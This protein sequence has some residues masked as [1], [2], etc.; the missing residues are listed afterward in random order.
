V[1]G[2]NEDLWGPN[3]LGP[4]RTLAPGLPEAGRITTL[5][6]GEPG[7]GEENPRPVDYVLDENLTADVFVIKNTPGENALK[8]TLNV[9]FEPDTYADY[10]AAVIAY[11]GTTVADE[12]MVV[13]TGTQDA[14]AKVAFDQDTEV[15]VIVVNPNWEDDS[16]GTSQ[17]DV[18]VGDDSPCGDLEEP[19]LEIDN[20]EALQAA[21]ETPPSGGTI[22]LA[23]GTYYPPTKLWNDVGDPQPDTREAHL[24][25]DGVTLAGSGIEETTIITTDDALPIFVRG[26]SSLRDL[27]IVGPSGLWGSVLY[28]ANPRD[29]RMCNVVVDDWSSEGSG[30]TYEAWDPGTFNVTIHNCIL[31]SHTAPNE[32]NWGIEFENW[33]WGD[34]API[35]NLDLKKTEFY[36]WGIGVYID[37][38]DPVNR[39]TV[40]VDTDCYFFSR[41][42]YHNVWEWKGT[43]G[44]EHCP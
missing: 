24:M 21:L 28:I 44:V 41:V 33:R 37:N 25:L 15:A 32:W 14:T 29:F 4:P 16:R 1:D 43:S 2:G 22:R 26:S 35:I 13:V 6:K 17:C 31:D 23:P 20:V 5:R 42:T 38:Q 30:I 12:T 10:E 39:G 40:V 34:T 19:I 9:N 36:R 18:W 7:D 11:K 27:T 3:K 8:G